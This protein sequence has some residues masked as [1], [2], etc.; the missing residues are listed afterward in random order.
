MEPLKVL[1]EEPDAAGPLPEPLAVLYG[2]G[3][4]LADDILYANLIASVDGV[5]AL[6]APRGA[7]AA[8]RGNC[9]ADRFVMALLRD[10]ADAVLVGAGTLRAD[11]GHLWTPAYIDRERADLHRAGGRPDPRLVVV[12]ASGEL[13]PGER[14]LRAGAL[15]L[16]TEAGFL[17]LARRLPPACTVRSLGGDTPTGATI[18]AAVRAE[19]YRRVLTEGGP[20]L[21]ARFVSEGLL[22]ELFLTLSPVLAGRRSGDGRLGLLEGVELLPGD[23]R[24][25]RLRSLRVAGSHLFLRYAFSPGARVSRSGAE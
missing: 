20:T 5:S 13:D 15:V 2:G 21:L 16:T 18:L 11:R 17:R 22:D 8:L 6:V 25:G 23:G 12:T 19:G 3:L 1:F 4:R 7:G 10:L 9:D 24:W 14:A